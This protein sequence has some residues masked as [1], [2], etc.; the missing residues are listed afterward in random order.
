MLVK[1][2]FNI[3]V[4][5]IGNVVTSFKRFLKVPRGRFSIF[6]KYGSNPHPFIL[7]L[8]SL[9]SKYNNSTGN[10]VKSEIKAKNSVR[11]MKRPV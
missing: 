1:S 9:F 10:R 3:P 4:L 6:R 5:D 7:T 11:L 8:P 2:I